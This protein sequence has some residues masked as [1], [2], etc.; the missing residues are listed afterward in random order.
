MSVDDFSKTLCYFPQYKIADDELIGFKYVGK[1]HPQKH[2]FEHNG[3]QVELPDIKN[4]N[5]LKPRS[6]LYAKSEYH[7]TQNKTDS[8]TPS[9]AFNKLINMDAIKSRLPK[10]NFTSAQPQNSSIHPVTLSFF[11]DKRADALLSLIICDDGEETPAETKTLVEQALGSIHNEIFT[12]RQEFLEKWCMTLGERVDDICQKEIILRSNDADDKLS[13]DEERQKEAKKKA[14]QFAFEAICEMAKILAVQESDGFSENASKQFI[15]NPKKQPSGQIFSYIEKYC[16]DNI[17]SDRKEYVIEFC[18]KAEMY[19]EQFVSSEGNLK[20]RLSAPTVRKLKRISLT[21]NPVNA[22]ILIRGEPGGGK[23]ATAEDFHLYCMKRIAEEIQKIEEG[24]IKNIVK[25]EIDALGDGNDKKEKMK[26]LKNDPYPY[27]LTHSKYSQEIQKIGQD[28][29]NNIAKFEIDAQEGGDDEVEEK[30]EHVTDLYTYLIKH[31]KYLKEVEKKLQ[32]IFLLPAIYREISEGAEADF[33]MKQISNTGWWTWNRTPDNKK[34]KQEELLKEL[35]SSITALNDVQKEIKENIRILEKKTNS[36]HKEVGAALNFFGISDDPKEK[37]RAKEAKGAKE[38]LI[39]LYV[40]LLRNKIKYEDSSKK[41]DWSFNFLQVNCGI[42]GGKNSELAE[43]IERLF[44]KAGDYQKAMPGLFQTC[45][46]MGGTLFLDEIADAPLRIQDNLLRPLEEETVSRPGW[47][48]FDE[49]ED[50]I[51]IVGA[52]FKDLFKL[53]QQYQE[54]LPSGNPKGFRP[55]LL[56]RLTRNTPVA[57][58]PVWNYFVPTKI[59]DDDFSSQFAFVLNNSWE[60]S[61]AFWLDVYFMVFKQIDE[62]VF[63][64]RHHIPAGTE[65]RRKFASKLTMR[66]FKEVGKIARLNTKSDEKPEESD[67]QIN[68]A[69]HYLRRM[70]DYLLVETN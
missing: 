7:L 19:A 29:I 34:G 6:N 21:S 22:R 33:F 24:W 43:A 49:E 12:R 40:E 60:V 38:N 23:G 28:R 11:A 4:V 10:N 65:G 15:Y 58:S 57:V 32:E 25:F 51:R 45:S 1:G 53:A 63:K 61:T 44:G 42:L 54:T 47:E 13:D 18:K 5:N 55:D 9:S 20:G 66:L 50:N 41:P 52:T 67:P 64:A 56:T 35:N 46:Y 69:K 2:F 3:D 59:V 8:A 16:V 30:K 68:K 39:K 37:D 70:L 36:A 26:E 14:M 62:H 27:L 31:S 17:S 48:T